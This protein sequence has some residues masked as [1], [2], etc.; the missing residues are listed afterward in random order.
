MLIPVPLLI[1]QAMLVLYFGAT[2]VYGSVTQVGPGV[3][4]LCEAPVRDHGSRAGVP[5]V[6]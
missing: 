6:E 5:C 3:L 1:T 4:V 2:I